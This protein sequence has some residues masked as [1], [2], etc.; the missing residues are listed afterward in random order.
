MLNT[1]NRMRCAIV[2]CAIVLSMICAG[3]A[4]AEN[5]S[6]EQSI[7]KVFDALVA[8]GLKAQTAG[9][10]SATGTLLVFRFGEVMWIFEDASRV[11]RTGVW[12]NVP[13]VT[14]AGE[15]K[16]ADL[17]IEGATIKGF[18]GFSLN[19]EYLEYL[20]SVD[21]IKLDFGK[22]EAEKVTLTVDTN[23][24]AQEKHTVAESVQVEKETTYTSVIIDASGLGAKRVLKPNIV[25]PE[26]K[27]VHG[28][29][30]NFSSSDME[31]VDLIRYAGSMEEA[32]GWKVF[33]GNKPLIIKAVGVAGKFK[34]D[35]VVSKE[36]AEK[37]KNAN[38]KGNVLMKNRV[39]V[40]L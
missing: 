23:K 19:G 36:D 24:A 22:T 40:I 39:A 14:A 34:G 6:G 4:R 20:L 2:A 10:K 3:G 26:G 27:L 33:A 12:K 7:V 35:I 38:E 11:M 28:Y 13:I 1:A 25:T 15:R 9:G 17:E 30:R 21:G 18:D 37:M 16:F 32:Q 8:T 31:T 5:I 29:A